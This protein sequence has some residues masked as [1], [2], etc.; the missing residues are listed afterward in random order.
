MFDE[1][2]KAINGCKSYKSSTGVSYYLITG[3]S[4][5]TTGV[6]S[7]DHGKGFSANVSY[8]KHLW[9]FER[10]DS[11]TVRSQQCLR[12]GETKSYYSGD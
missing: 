9:G 6:F 5:Y 7:P 12:C 11:M 2:V 1:E 8:C 3:D 4:G 10:Q